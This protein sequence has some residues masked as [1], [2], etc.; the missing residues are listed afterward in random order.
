MFLIFSDERF[1]QFL[2]L[3][4]IL[5]WNTDPIVIQFH[6][7]SDFQVI[8]DPLRA[9]IHIEVGDVDRFANVFCKLFDRFIRDGVDTWRINFQHVFFQA[10]SIDI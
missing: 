10:V 5:D 4:H 2:R 9:L 8:V 7:P 3:V 1:E 6:N